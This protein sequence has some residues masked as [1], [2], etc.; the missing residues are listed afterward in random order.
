[1]LILAEC[2][3]GATLSQIR[4]DHVGRYEWADGI[5]SGRILDVACGCGYGAALLAHSGRSILAVDRRHEAIE[6]AE[7]NWRR[8]GVEFLLSDVF[9]IEETRF[10]WAVC[11]ETLEHLDQDIAFLQKLRRM[12]SRL[13]ISVP[14]ERVIPLTPGHF[15]FHFRHYTPEQF[16]EVLSLGGWLVTGLLHQA[17]AFTRRLERGA[18]GRTI[19][20]VCKAQ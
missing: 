11:F 9:D 13:L 16:V 4:A 7:T 14:N 1:M 19:I 20:A 17:D 10:D 12:T 15:T 3:F 8:P 6:Y 2:Q 5:V 18:S